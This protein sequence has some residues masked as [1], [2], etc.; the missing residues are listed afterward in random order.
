[1]EVVGIRGCI[2]LDYTTVLVGRFLRREE[3]RLRKQHGRHCHDAE[4]SFGTIAGEDPGTKS[5]G[6]ARRRAS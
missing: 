5:R 1:M 6:K 3:D 2:K 4:A